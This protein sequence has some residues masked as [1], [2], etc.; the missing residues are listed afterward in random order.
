MVCQPQSRTKKKKKE[1][2]PP[3]ARDEGTCTSELGVLGQ[4]RGVPYDC[5][6]KQDHPGML[7]AKVVEILQVGL[8]SRVHPEIVRGEV[9]EGQE[10][11]GADEDADEADYEVEGGDGPTVDEGKQCDA[12]S[13]DR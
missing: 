10:A 9:V 8:K 3:A 4:G 1:F 13:Q 12:Q 7:L 6:A 11:G 2:S 5:G